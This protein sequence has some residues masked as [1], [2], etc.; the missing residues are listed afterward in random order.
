MKKLFINGLIWQGKSFDKLDIAVEDGVIAALEEHLYEPYSGIVD[1]QGAHII[2]GMIDMHVHVGEKVGGFDLAD[3]WASLSKLAS[4]CGISAIGA[5]ITEWS[6]SEPMKT[7]SGLY[8]Q[9]LFQAEMDFKHQVHWHLT[10]TVSGVKVVYPMLEKG[11]DLK[12][13]TT[14][15]QSGIYCSYDKIANWM[16]ELSDLKP[17]M[18]VHCEED[19]IVNSMSAYHPFH[20]PFDLTK[21]R[22]ELAE[23]KAVERVL[24]LAI[25]HDYPVH[26]VHVSSPKSAVLIN[27]ARQAAPVTCETA[28]QYLLL[29]ETLLQREDGHRWLCTP[30][31]RSE[32]SRGQMIELLQD[33]LFDA[34]AT[35][36]CPFT[37][38][39]KDRFKAN[40]EQVPSGL[41]GLGATLPLMY[42][43]LVKTGKITLE[44]LM[45]MLI[46]NPARIMKLPAECYEIKTGLKTGL[47]AIRDS[48]GKKK[49]VRPS[50]SDTPNPW[51][52]Y[53]TTLETE[54]LN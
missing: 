34:I 52:G 51:I 17:R 42:E 1:C 39:D 38:A 54:R 14:Y 44:N 18:L 28:P 9:A 22:P 2:P 46:D 32:Q 4:D 11:C 24:D 47:Y 21:R 6:D 49:A 41:A 27:E 26:I 29:N 5:F 33:G 8:K 19:E 16:M 40:P 20:H 23:I 36:H 3:N 43:N 48:A 37:T 12:F 50:L 25:R 35:D 13:Y 45:P 31:L 10:P 30:P 53:S 7:L 15:K